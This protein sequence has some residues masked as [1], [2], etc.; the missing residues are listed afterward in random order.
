MT[1]YG[2]VVQEEEW[3]CGAACVASLLGVSYEDAK[4]LVEEEKGIAIDKGDCKNLLYPGLDLHHLA[5][6]L[7]KKIIMVADW[8]KHRDFPD[9][10]IACIGDD[11]KY[12]DEHYILKT[13][14]GWMDPWLNM[15]EKPMKAG[16][17]KQYPKGTWFVVALV[18]VSG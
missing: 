4:T 17:R 15:G 9:G 1:Q 10:T 16:Y 8:R 13:P 6:A 5:L 14:H 7:K 11:D 3:G 18:P 12:K 2:L